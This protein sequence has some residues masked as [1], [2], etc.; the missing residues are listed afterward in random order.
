MRISEKVSGKAE[1]S[2]KNTMNLPASEYSFE[3]TTK[4]NQ[5]KPIK[6]TKTQ[7]WVNGTRHGEQ[8]IAG[9]RISVI[10]Y[11]WPLISY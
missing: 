6:K 2:D 1:L 8:L 9:E 11:V 4:K 5:Q 7:T 10:T 3:A